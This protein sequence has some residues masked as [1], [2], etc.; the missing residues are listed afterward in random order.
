MAPGVAGPEVEAAV[1]AAPGEEPRT[2]VEAAR[3]WDEAAKL[4]PFAGETPDWSKALAEGA[5]MTTEVRLLRL[6]GGD[7]VWTEFTGIRLPGHEW[8]FS[9]SIASGVKSS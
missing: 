1:A 5:R 3:S 4:L 7:V 6:D 2:P 8:D 9:T